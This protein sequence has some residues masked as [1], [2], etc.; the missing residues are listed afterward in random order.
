MENFFACAGT[1][2]GGNPRAVH[3]RHKRDGHNVR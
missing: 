3:G 1:L 2:A